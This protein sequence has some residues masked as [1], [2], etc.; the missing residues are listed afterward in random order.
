[1]FVWL[2]KEIKEL[3]VEN[4][5]K[6][7][8]SV[9]LSTTQMMFLG[10]HIDRFYVLHENSS[11]TSFRDWESIKNFS[12]LRIWAKHSTAKQRKEDKKGFVHAKEFS[13]Y[14]IE[15]YSAK[16]KR[17][18]KIDW[19]RQRG[20]CLKE[21]QMIFLLLLK[22]NSNMQFLFFFLILSFITFSCF[23]D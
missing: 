3:F 15:S 13:M 18:N 1:M 2:V 21:K 22:R 20:D 5:Q 17:R 16:H 8:F 11:S 6:K 10:L 7:N 12:F 4:F 19:R 9:K 23:K 14:N